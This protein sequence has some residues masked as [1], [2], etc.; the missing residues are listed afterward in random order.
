MPGLPYT[1]HG[2]VVAVLQAEDTLRAAARAGEAR[3]FME[4]V[5]MNLRVRSAA[6]ASAMPA[7]SISVATAW[8]D[9]WKAATSRAAQREHEERSGDGEGRNC[10]PPR[11]AAVL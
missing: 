6:R 7:F 4:H 1:S 5:G 11:S 3:S 8:S 10:S 9:S 2:T